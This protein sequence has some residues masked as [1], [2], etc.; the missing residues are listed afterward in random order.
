MYI[1]T[2]LIPIIKYVRTVLFDNLFIDPNMFY[3]DNSNKQKKNLCQ[4]SNVGIVVL[5]TYL[6][7]TVSEM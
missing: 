2:F 6:E 3:N 5:L 1:H 7:I 4:T